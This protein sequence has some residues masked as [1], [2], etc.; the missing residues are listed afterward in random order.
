MANKT[1]F[2]IQEI[3]NRC[4]DSTNNCL[5][6]SGTNV[7][8]PPTK[9][10]VQHILNKVFNAAGN[11]LSITANSAPNPNHLY[12]EREIWS[13]V[14]NEAGGYISISTNSAPSELNKYTTQNI[15]NLSFDTSIN[16]FAVTTHTNGLP[17]TYY[18][19]QEIL[20]IL[21]DSTNNTLNLFS[22]L[23]YSPS[24]Y[25]PSTNPNTNVFS[26][27]AVQI[28]AADKAYL[29]IASNDSLNLG[30]GD[31]AFNIWFLRGATG[32]KVFA[33]KYQ[34]SNNY[35]EFGVNSG[36]IPYFT[37]IIGGSTLIS[38]IG[39]TAITST[40][41]W[42]D[43]HIN[44][45]RS[46]AT[47]CKIYVNGTD[48]TV[49]GASTSASTIDNTGSF[50]FGANGALTVFCQ[51]AKD[52]FAFTK[53][54]S[55]TDEITALY[56]AGA[57]RMYDDLTTANRLA[58][59]QTN[60]I[61]WWGFNEE[62]GTRYDQKG[63]N[64]L[65]QTFAELVTNGTFTGNDTG[66]TPGAGWAYGT[67]NEAATAATA[68]LAQS[69]VVP[70]VGHKYKVTYDVAAVTGSVAFTLGGVTGATRST[71]G[72]F[73][74]YITATSAAT[75][76]IH[77]VAAFT[78]TI[79]N[80]SV[81]CTEVGSATGIAAGLS[82]DGNRGVQFTTSNQSLTKTSNSTI[83]SGSGD[84][85]IFG[86]FNLA[87]VL[88]GTQLLAFKYD[89]G[90]NKRE[91]ALAAT[92]ITFN[93]LAS[94]SGSSPVTAS[95]GT[96]TANNWFFLIGEFNSST[97]KIKLTVNGVAGSDASLASI[98]QSDSPLTISITS[99]LG[100][101]DGV[102]LIKRLL[103]D[104]EKTAM[105]NNGKGVKYAGLPSTVSADSTLSFWNLDEYSAGTGAV[106]RKDSSA[107]AN[108][109]TDSGNTPS[110]QGVNYLAG[111]VSK[112]VDSATTPHN[113]T[114]TTLAARPLYVTNVK[115]GWPMRFYNGVNSSLLNAGDLIGTG[116]VTFVAVIRP[117]GWGGGG[118]G[119][120]IDNSQFIF[121]V[122][123]TNSQLFCGNA[124]S[125]NTNSAASS[126]S[127]GNYYVVTLTRTSAGV[128]N[129]YINGALS[130][131]ANQA[132]T[133]PVSGS[134]TYLGNRA[135]GDRGFQGMM[136]STVIY[137]KI[138]SASE[139]QATYNYLKAKYAI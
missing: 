139:I 31:F 75:L 76:T 121:G 42:Q 74:E 132:G 95:A 81:T 131:T 14:F 60:L 112:I 89:S 73:T 114:Q 30:T 41:V 91:Y 53:T 83:Q 84:F 9:M 28:T 88:S 37:A 101:A 34:D 62:D 124:G 120:I 6:T 64:H 57:G 127:L 16:G 103:S 106:T 107:N 8:N 32:A 22:P 118:T 96:V 116:D 70:T 17:V 54:L 72:T 45:S 68:D 138:L 35:W 36:N 63:T 7:G 48:D 77:P 59:F 43:L 39:T 135:A 100:R 137:P 26:D 33:T 29:S 2:S 90:S 18:N 50:I 98:Y 67:N 125:G 134:V 111:T 46:S 66:W 104:G 119:R 56:N 49:A 97:G 5:Y 79:D 113:L 21:F 38:V 108:D 92:A 44:I 93:F 40:T 4:F 82:I 80:V 65:A 129:F 105:I 27:S 23:A 117:D 128:I 123:T 55:T 24:A 61:S 115:N 12:N 102:G 19:L 133:T 71:T 58:T 3:L 13:R 109:L 25:F 99:D 122:T 87:S 94:S 52:S 78:G 110:G 15:T 1:Q 11:Y 20:N 10:T 136:S 126:I 86:W 69:T 130:G 85:S 47:A 51:G